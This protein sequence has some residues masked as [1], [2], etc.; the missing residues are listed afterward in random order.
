MIRIRKLSNPIMERDKLRQ[1]YIDTVP[2]IENRLS[3]AKFELER[4]KL[5]N[6]RSVILLKTKR[7]SELK[8]I[9][10]DYKLL[11]KELK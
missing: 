8:R 4:A 7:I 5:S 3:N 11:I 1:W 2:I 10:D 6:N 9:L